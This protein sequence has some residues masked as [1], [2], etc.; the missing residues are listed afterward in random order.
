[1]RGMDKIATPVTQGWVNMV[2][3][4]INYSEE[5]PQATYYSIYDVK[6]LKDYK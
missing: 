3:P 4:M 6:G 1:M 2:G 5:R